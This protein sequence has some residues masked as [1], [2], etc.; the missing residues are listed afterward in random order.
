MASLAGSAM[1]SG[2]ASPG[3]GG[4]RAGGGSHVSTP[5][6]EDATPQPLLSNGGMAAATVASPVSLAAQTLRRLVQPHRRL[7]L[8]VRTRKYRRGLHCL[9][10]GACGA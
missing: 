4:G 10:V 9:S 5:D 1:S 3:E 7:R 8:N 6:A 2:A